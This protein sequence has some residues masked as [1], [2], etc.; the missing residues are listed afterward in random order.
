MKAQ[1]ALVRSSSRRS[2][3]LWGGWAL[4]ACCLA[5]VTFPAPAAAQSRA[6]SRNSLAVR[7]AFKDVIAD[8]RKSVVRVRSEGRTL[9]LGTVVDAEGY[10]LTKAS[11]LTGPL[12]CLLADG[13]E[14][15]A[16]LIGVR[17]DYDLAML[18][19]EANDLVP[20]SWNSEAQEVTGHWVVTPGIDED[21]VSVGIISNTRRQ[22]RAVSGILGITMGAADGGA[23]VTEVAEGSGAAK[24]GLQVDDVIMY[25]NRSRVESSDQ[26][27]D[28]LSEFSVGD[29]IRL[30]IRRGENESTVDAKLGPRTP[31]ASSQGR[32]GRGGRGGGRGRSSFQ[33]SMGGALSDRSAGFPSAI[34][35]DTV[36][37]PSECGGP[38]LDLDGKV[39]GVNIAR[40][41]RVMSFALPAK[42][43]VALLDDLKSGKYCPYIDFQSDDADD[44]AAAKT[45]KSGD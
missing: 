43:V 21:P 13:R 15:S 45:D 31:P 26:L 2:L 40:A 22:I 32:G 8:A 11:E 30:R 27:T 18:K 5:V 4:T 14:L 24:A 7:A 19:V 35:H 44:M 41:G 25:V 20:A 17:E 28:V 39:I 36:L 29:I 3:C 10:I 12:A 16:S 37:Q 33:N 42:D 9:A 38:L 1:T 23:K 34:Q 6:N